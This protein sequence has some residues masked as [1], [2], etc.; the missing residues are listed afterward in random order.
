[1]YLSNFKENRRDLCLY[2]FRFTCAYTT[3]EG[4]YPIAPQKT[5]L[6][7]TI[8]VLYMWLA[9]LLLADRIVHKPFLHILPMYGRT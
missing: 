7:Y 3:N 1:M 6:L 4:T 8:Y 5:H 9:H 2:V